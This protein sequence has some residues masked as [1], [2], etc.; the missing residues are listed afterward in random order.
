MRVELDATP[1]THRASGVQH[2]RTGGPPR[3]RADC[4]N[5]HWFIPR[6]SFIFLQLVSS[7]NFHPVPRRRVSRCW[8]GTTACTA[9]CR[10][11][12]MPTRSWRPRTSQATQRRRP[13]ISPT[14]QAPNVTFVVFTPAYVFGR[15]VC[16][17]KG[18]ARENSRLAFRVDLPSTADARLPF[19]VDPSLLSTL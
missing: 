11:A 1:R 17:L 9:P 2:H 18:L 12:A 6:R 10:G 7:I 15:L 13:L 5:A 8:V 14:R 19:A 4:V 3:I 16:R